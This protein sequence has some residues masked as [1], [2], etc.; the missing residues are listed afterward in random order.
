MVIEDLLLGYNSE[1]ACIRGYVSLDRTI[2]VYRLRLGEA[3]NGRN[4]S[5]NIR[6]GWYA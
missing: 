1:S 2:E 4:M 5:S 3:V 6:S